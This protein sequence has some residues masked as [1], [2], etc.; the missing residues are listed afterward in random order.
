[1]VK[2]VMVFMVSIFVF[3]I[4]LS[5][6]YARCD[7]SRCASGCSMGTRSC[8]GG[9]GS[10]EVGCEDCSCKPLNSSECECK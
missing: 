10:G 3:G 1:M 6:L 4:S 7:G 9:C 2:L 5:E 8:T